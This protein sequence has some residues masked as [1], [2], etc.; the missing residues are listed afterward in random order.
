MATKVDS[1][2]SSGR[3]SC[4]AASCRVGR[5]LASPAMPHG[6]WP[7]RSVPSLCAPSL[8]ARPSWP[9]SASRCGFESALNL[10][11]R[12]SVAVRSFH[13]WNSSSRMDSCP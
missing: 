8:P 11:A 5:A 13:A 9:M 7:T 12:T 4:R 1:S 3:P 10:S 2:A 6:M